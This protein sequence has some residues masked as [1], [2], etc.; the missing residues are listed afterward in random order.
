MTTCTT[1]L[2]TSEPTILSIMQNDHEN[3]IPDSGATEHMT[4]NPIPEDQSK[5]T[6]G[7]CEH[8]QV[9]GKGDLDIW[10]SNP[11]GQWEKVTLKDILYI[12]SLK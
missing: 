11:S 7:D 5:D 9:M 12:P 8:L 6:I 10:V 2:S 4:I 1:V 3:F